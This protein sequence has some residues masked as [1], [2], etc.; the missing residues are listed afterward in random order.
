MLALLVALTL[1]QPVQSY[2]GGDRVPRDNRCSSRDGTCG[3]T[4]P[5]F[6]F[7]SVSGA[8]MG[9]QCAG[10]IPTGTKAEA[11]TFTRASVAECYSNDGQKL[12]QMAINQPAVSS[13]AIT[14]SI[15][16]VW[17]EV[18]HTNYL[19]FSRNLADASWTKSANMT[20][21]RTA[22][23]M[24]NN[25]VNG[26]S[27]CT[28]S[29]ATQTVLH[30]ITYASQLSASSLHIK[31]RT[32][33]GIVSVT[34]NGGTNWFDIT[35]SLSSSVWKRVVSMETPGCTSCLPNSATCTNSNCIV[36]AGMSSTLANPSIGIQISTNGD[37]VDVDFAQDED[38]A[39][40][41][42]PIDNTAAVQNVRSPTVFDCPLAITNP[43]SVSLSATM[44]TA[45]SFSAGGGPVPLVLGN[46]TLGSTTGPNP[47]VWLYAPLTAGRVA[48]D[49]STIATAVNIYD[50][51]F[52][53]FQGTVS[54]NAAY[55]TG[56]LIDACQENVCAVGSASTLS[57]FTFTR[58]L[59]GRYSAALANQF[60]GV[61]SEVCVE[62]S[63][64]C[65]PAQ[66]GGPVVW[67][68]DSIVYG[69]ASLP[70]SPPWQLTRLIGKGV[71]NAG[72]GGN[73]IAQCTARWESTYRFA[74]YQ[75][76][77]WSCAVNDL[78]A[79]RT[80]AAMASDTES[81]LAE[82]KAAGMKVIVTGVMPW[83]TSAGWT[84]G[85]NTEGL[86]YNTALAAYCAVGA[87]GCTY[88]SMDNL[89]SG[90]PLVILPQFNSSDFIHPDA[91]GTLLEA[92]NVQAANP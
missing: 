7:G 87:N 33:T 48:D 26:A 30:P 1:A 37:A 85:E 39:F 34:R 84:S 27:T 62:P 20:C 29:A 16:G 66:Q 43:A 40:S 6:S 79:A 67:L 57:A 14:R 77:I 32:G 22:N 71:V 8:G 3:Q 82:A 38:G 23:G 9:T 44:V 80:G 28:A 42:S 19:T 51:F 81:V 10:T 13:G 15:L 89:G 88:V 2:R 63:L 25:D 78:V 35:A 31:R 52:T 74:G 72:V 46:G 92:Q 5:F 36:V 45:Q 55:H 65:V 56:S 59:F 58:T 41:T 61:I 12:T 69:N 47:Y 68:G 75:T 86:N 4:L 53:P 70:E 17:V 73:T 18:T 50:G 76:L 21:T 11:C 24:R 60:S 91:S 64:S 83:A 49:M 90:S 54:H